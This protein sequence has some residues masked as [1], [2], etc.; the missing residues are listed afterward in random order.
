LSKVRVLLADDHPGLLELVRSLLKADIDLV[1]CVDNG[2]SL[3]EAA[4]ELR[5]D[6]IVTDISMPRLN[7]IVA[8]ERLRDS[9]C[10]SKVVFLTALSDPDFVSAGLKTGAL[11]YVFKSS[12]TTDL[13]F[14]IQEALAGRVFV[15]CQE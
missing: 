4:M 11:A 13:V 12:M 3:F 14:A 8:V 5:P 6:I 7:G 2:E 9:G 15:S 1:G 10:L